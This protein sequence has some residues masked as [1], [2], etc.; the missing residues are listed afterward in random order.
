MDGYFIANDLNYG[1]PTFTADH[2]WLHLEARY[3]YENLRTA[4]L[5][6]GYNFAWGK[7]WQFAVTPMVGAVF[8]ELNG[9][10]PGCEASLTYKKVALSISNEYVIAPGNTQ[11]NFYYSW[12]Q[13]TISPTN[14]FNFGGVAQRTK[15]YKTSMDVQRG[16][17]VGFSHKKWELTT[18]IFNPGMSDLTVVGEFGV[19]F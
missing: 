6:T 17:F 15:A 13:L 1:S 11:Q 12:P 10:A 3:N 14:W 18:Y 16:F 8:G 2:N 9:F 19:S 7:K 4:S 5:W